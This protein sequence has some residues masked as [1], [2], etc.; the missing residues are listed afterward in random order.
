[1]IAFKYKCQPQQNQNAFSSCPWLYAK[2]FS[3]AVC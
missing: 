2:T 3:A 1:M